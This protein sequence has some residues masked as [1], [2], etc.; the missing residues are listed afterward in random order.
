MSTD[1]FTAMY[2]VRETWP[3]DERS[4]RTCAYAEM[5]LILTSCIY[6]QTHTQKC[7]QLFSVSI[8]TIQETEITQ[9]GE[10]TELLNNF[11]AVAVN[12]SHCA[13]QHCSRID[14]IYKCPCKNEK[15]IKESRLLMAC[16]SC[17]GGF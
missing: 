16:Q 13:L 1:S 9:F 7:T 4:D 11:D 10:S 14:E 3:G 8:L 6:R 12:K 2:F 17:Y 5:I 15:I